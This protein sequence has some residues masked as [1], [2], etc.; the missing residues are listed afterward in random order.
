MKTCGLRLWGSASL[1]RKGLRSASKST[2]AFYTH[3]GNIE[4][5]Q[6]TI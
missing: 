6:K 5:G 1:A 3:K 2:K 4:Y